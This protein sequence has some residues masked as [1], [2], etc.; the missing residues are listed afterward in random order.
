MGARTHTAAF[1]KENQPLA[2]KI[3]FF[4]LVVQSHDKTKLKPFTFL[5]NI[6]KHTFQEKSFNRGDEIIY[7]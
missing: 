5:I 3:H 6:F 4:N 2:Q 1:F 7:T